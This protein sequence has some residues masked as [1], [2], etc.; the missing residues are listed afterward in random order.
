MAQQEKE[1]MFRFVTSKQSP[2]LATGIAASAVLRL[3]VALYVGKKYIAWRHVGDLLNRQAVL[4][5]E[6]DSGRLVR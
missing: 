5:S 3:T 4:S 6:G 1:S 2:F